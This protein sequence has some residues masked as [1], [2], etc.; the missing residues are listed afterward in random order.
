MQVWLECHSLRKVITSIWILLFSIEFV[1]YLS[2]SKNVILPGNEVQFRG[3]QMPNLTLQNPSARQGSLLVF[4]TDWL[5][6]RMDAAKENG[7]LPKT[8]SGVCL[9]ESISSLIMCHMVFLSLICR[10]I[11]R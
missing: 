7:H 1:H 9:K 3:Q 11:S 5:L 2:N 8:R 4:V 6:S 10:C